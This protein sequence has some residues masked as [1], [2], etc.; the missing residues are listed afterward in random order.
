MFCFLACP[1]LP[2]CEGVAFPLLDA[3]LE[4]F[5]RVPAMFLTAYLACLWRRVFF[6]SVS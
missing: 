5:Q 6:L 1:A 3:L 2:L 4:R